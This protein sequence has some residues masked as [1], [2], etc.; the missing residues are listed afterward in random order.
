M[1]RTACSVACLLAVASLCALLPAADEVRLEVPPGCRAAEG[2]EAEPYTQTGYAGEVVHQVSGITLLFV[3]A[4]SYTMGGRTTITH[5]PPHTVTIAGAFYMGKHEVTNAQFRKFVSAT[6]YDGKADS[7][8]VYHHFLKHFRGGST[9]PQGDGFPVVWVNWKHAQ[10]YCRWAGLRLPTEAQWEY[11]C[12]AGTTTLYSFG[13]RQED[14]AKYGWSTENADGATHEVG[15][16]PPNG[17]GFH[18]MH[19]NVWEWCEDDMVSGYEGAP[20]DG[21]ARL[22]GLMTKVLRSGSWSN[23]ARPHL[24]SSEARFNSGPT[25]ASNNAGFRVVL[26]P[27]RGVRR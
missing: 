27:G 22:E 9:M 13:D 11:A 6:G 23:D 19:G 12:R 14:F 25:N 3:P 5:E 10:A 18:D 17:W 15:L 20:A 4:G 24:A 26:S 2:T 1:S 16:K 7:D 21:S 8:P